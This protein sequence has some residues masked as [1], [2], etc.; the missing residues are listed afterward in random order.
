MEWRKLMA[1]VIGNDNSN[2]LTG[3]NGADTIK[4]YGGNDFLKGG[5]GSDYLDGGTGIDT[6]MFTN[7]PG[8]VRVDL[9]TGTGKYNFLPGDIRLYR[10]ENVWGSS[11]NDTLSGDNGA[12]ELLGLDGNDSLLGAGGAD[13]LDGGY[14]DDGLKGGAGADILN[15]G[16]GMDWAYYDGSPAGVTVNLMNNTASGGD[17]EGDTVI[18][19]EYVFASEFK[20]TL[21]GDNNANVFYGNGGNDWL[22]GYGGAD[23][24]FGF[25]GV[26]VLE[27]M[28]GDDRLFG[29]YDDDMLTGGMGRD[30][31][32]GGTGADRFVWY[33]T[34]ETGTTTGTADMVVDFN[35]SQGDRIDLSLVD[36]NVYAAGDQAFRFI[37]TN[38]FS[39]T[40]G[41][42]NYYHLDGNTYIQMQTGE[43]A[44]VEGVIRL[45]GIHTPEAGWFV[46]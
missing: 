5:G 11:Y 1:T 30:E 25:L 29:E 19:I 36:A 26:D 40:P 31:L 42:I 23:V 20:D 6:A 2:W 37:G 28:D 13:V 34:D 44:D 43:S 45:N 27:G 35:F 16:P 38:A 4:G 24:M 8:S 10:I 3:T 46:L 41:E 15:G 7:S 32:G 33:S 14:G 12:N 17:A 21:V 9:Q 39:G 22:Q 18:G